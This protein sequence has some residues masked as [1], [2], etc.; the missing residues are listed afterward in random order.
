MKRPNLKSLKKAKLELTNQDVVNL[1]Q[2][3]NSI[4]GLQGTKLVYA[5]GRTIDK[6]NPVVKRMAQDECIPKSE[7]F[8][9]YEQA[10]HE[11]HKK[12][13]GGKTRQTEAGT[14]F[15]FPWDIE[16]DIPDAV[17]KKREKW[18][19]EREE[20]QE[21]HIKAVEEREQ[22]LQDYFEYMEEPFSEDLGDFTHKISE[23][24]LDKCTVPETMRQVIGLLVK[25]Q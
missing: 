13:S 24:D 7:A 20:L 21:K 16:E 25:Q 9:K 1:H 17:E 11:L 18:L 19:K 10:L 2:V 6:L 12:Y 15:L 22:Q 23:E 8:K 5:V 4:K 14:Y 3:L